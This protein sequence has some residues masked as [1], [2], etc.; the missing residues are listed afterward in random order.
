[1][2]VYQYNLDDLKKVDDTSLESKY[3]MRKYDCLSRYPCVL[4]QQFTSRAVYRHVDAHKFIVCFQYDC[5]V[6][7]CASH[8]NWYQDLHRC[9]I[10]IDHV[11]LLHLMNVTEEDEDTESYIRNMKTGFY[12]A[13]NSSS[14]NYSEENLLAETPRQ[15]N[16]N[17]VKSS[18]NDDEQ[19][20]EEKKISKKDEEEINKYI[21]AIH[22]ESKELESE[23]G[24]KDETTKSRFSSEYVLNKIFP[25]DL[26][27]EFI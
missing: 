14:R 9:L 18:K 23:D 24:S 7:E 4:N 1:M 22:E 8:M 2:E 16:A 20:G 6:H 21:D 3:D 15:T 5:S 25:K 13:Y 27:D 17:A 10:P 19:D 12:D 11:R 26:F